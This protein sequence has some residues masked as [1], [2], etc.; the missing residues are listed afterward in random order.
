[1]NSSTMS[2]AQTKGYEEQQDLVVLDGSD[3]PEYGYQYEYDAAGQDPSDDGQIGDESR[4]SPVQGDANQDKRDDL[5]SREE[6]IT[7]ELDAH[8]DKK[9]KH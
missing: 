4:G 9:G 3:E 5:R 2:R 6:R 7:R 1:M 8:S